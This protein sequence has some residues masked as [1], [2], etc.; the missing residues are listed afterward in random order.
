[1]YY[2]SNSMNVGAGQIVAAQL[3]DRTYGRVVKPIL[4]K[5]KHETEFHQETPL[6]TTK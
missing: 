1:M 4:V 5:L 2:P 3:S 6:L